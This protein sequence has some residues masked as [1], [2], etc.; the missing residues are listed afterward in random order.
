[1]QRS[2]KV[3]LLATS[4]LTCLFVFTAL[5]GVKVLSK[6]G[7]KELLSNPGFEA[8]P[9]PAGGWTL[10]RQDDWQ[11]FTSGTTE[12]MTLWAGA[13]HSGNQAVRFVSHG[14]PNFYQGLYQ[15]VPVVHGETYRFSVYVKNDSTHP[16]KG[17]V[18]GQLSLEWHDADG[19]EMGRLWSPAWGASLST[20][21]WTR[22]EVVGAAPPN[23][24]KAHCVIVEKGQG[25]PV[26]NGVFLVDD[27]SVVK[28]SEE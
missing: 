8:P 27:A 6:V 25:Q 11:T 13:A 2:V 7:P 21:D 28:V 1:M 26:A 18:I 16:L 9:L 22:F 23:A 15:A 24:A 12:L 20:T 4:T 10:I 14:I 17:S 19:G 3:G 5:S